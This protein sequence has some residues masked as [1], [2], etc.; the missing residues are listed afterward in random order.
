MLQMF[1]CGTRF[2]LYCLLRKRCH[3]QLCSSCSRPLLSLQSCLARLVGTISVLERLLLWH[4][5]YR[6]W[7]TPLI[8]TLKCMLCF[9]S[10]RILKEVFFFY[11]FVVY[12]F[13][14]TLMVKWLMFF[15]PTLLM[16]HGM[17]THWKSECFTLWHSHSVSQWLNHLIHLHVW[18]K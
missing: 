13:N 17:S 2:Q 10:Q 9:Q 16:T 15:V 1:F 14:Y 12:S 11:L 18:I 3:F 5:R 7:H 6:L 8:I 4:V